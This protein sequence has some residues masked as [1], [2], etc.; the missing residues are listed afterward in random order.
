MNLPSPQL[1]F[2]LFGLSEIGLAV[3]KRS[4]KTAVRRDQG[5][6]FLL[7]GM[8]GTAIFLAIYAT[9]AWP[10]FSYP[11]TL[12]GYAAGLLFFLA[13][14][15]LRWWSIVHLG[16]FFTVDVA[17]ARDHVVVGDGPYR[18]VRHPSYS[19]ALLSFVGLGCLLHNWLAAL[20]LL[21]P[22]T[23]AMLWRIKVEEAALSAALGKAYLDYMARTRR[24]VP[25][26][27]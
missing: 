1:F 2:I 21:L 13:G 20:L 24:L 17:I 16:R 15:V 5:S 7:W 25:W 27:Y 6:F 14:I 26:L 4:G 23:A 18:M 11:F 3:F 12:A 8:I 10:R 19:G 22:V 9:N